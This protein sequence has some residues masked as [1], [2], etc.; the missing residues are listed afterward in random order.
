MS[1][2]FSPARKLARFIATG[3][4]AVVAT[5]AAITVGVAPSY[6]NSTNFSGLSNAS[7]WGHMDVSGAST[8][9]GGR[10]IQWPA[11][12]ANNQQ[13]KYPARDGETSNILNQNSQMCVTT[14]G[15]AGHQ[16]FQMPCGGG[17]APYQRWTVHTYTPWYDFT[18]TYGW[19]TNP[20]TG[21]VIDV[22]G[23][24]RAQG[25]RIIAWYGNG[26]LNQSWIMT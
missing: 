16:L 25:T 12:G 15:V 23:G 7:T 9:P 4:L 17:W 26:G 18:N 10:I 24:S 20:A 21:L 1:K 3:V 8:S 19:F 22:E 14:D 13:F 2:T 6:A 11:N 5:A